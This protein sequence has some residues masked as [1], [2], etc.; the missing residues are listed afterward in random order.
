MAA[1]LATAQSRDP[2]MAAG[3]SHSLSRQR[4]DEHTA[5]QEGWTCIRPCG[6][7]RPKP[8][9]RHDCH[10]QSQSFSNLSPAPWPSVNLTTFLIH[11]V[12]YK[13]GHTAP[14]ESVVCVYSTGPDIN[15][16]PWPSIGRLSSSTGSDTNPGIRSGPARNLRTLG[17]HGGRIQIRSSGLVDEKMRRQLEG[18]TV[19]GQCVFLPWLVQ[20]DTNPTVHALGLSEGF[21]GAPWA[22][23]FAWLSVST[24]GYSSHRTSPVKKK[25]WL[26]T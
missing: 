18:L 24:G 12:G 21:L 20:S 10:V 26:C 2:D 16:A 14:H 8:T 7:E 19:Q 11:G 3:H 15:P 4:A 6:R 5:V 13:S 25:T 9:A 23:T 17:I 22:N 1:F